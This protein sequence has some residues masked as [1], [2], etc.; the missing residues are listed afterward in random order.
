[1][2]MLPTRSHRLLR[3]SVPSSSA[4]SKAITSL[5]SCR[6]PLTS[7]TRLF[8]VSSSS[9]SSRS[10]QRSLVTK[11]SVLLLNRLHRSLRTASNLLSC[12][13]PYA[14][15]FGGAT[16][17][18]SR[19]VLSRSALHSSTCSD[20]V[21]FPR[22]HPVTSTSR[23]PC[24]FQPQLSHALCAQASSESSLSLALVHVSPVVFRESSRL[25]RTNAPK[26]LDARSTLHLR[27]LNTS[28]SLGVKDSMTL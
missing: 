17:N 21:A 9:H 27:A 28:P 23:R 12:S 11:V 24:W 7:V 10:T 18:G 13:L 14:P 26:S 6:R 22:A 4:S 2:H 19:H 20:A 1:M 5:S 15:R 25:A 16:F 3:S 8:P